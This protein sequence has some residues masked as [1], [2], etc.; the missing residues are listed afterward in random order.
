MLWPFA[1]LRMFGY[2]VI[3]CDPPTEFVTHSEKGQAKS[4]GGQYVTMSWQAIA[5]L[6]FGQL[7]RA[8]AIF[9]LWA[10]PPT[11]RQSFWLLEQIGA[12]YKTELVWRKITKN[13][14]PR[15]GTGYR[16]A[17]YHESVLL[18]VFGDERQTHDQF[19]SMFDGVVRQ[20]SRK[21]DEFYQMVAERT[22]HAFRCD[23]FSRETRPGFEGWG[24]EHGLFDQ[25]DKATPKTTVPASSLPPTLPGFEVPA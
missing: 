3:V 21:P 4:G 7:A 17:G 18:S 5:A 11:L 14:K 9:L 15:R 24:L 20:H 23:L 13:G 22:P 1:P 8:N 19:R 25:D 10:C 16:S 6:P 2:D 12:K